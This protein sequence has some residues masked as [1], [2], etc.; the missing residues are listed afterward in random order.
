MSHRSYIYTLPIHALGKHFDYFFGRLNPAPSF[1][2]RAASEHQ[3]IIRL[4]EDASGLAAKFSPT[5]YLQGS[6]K[7]Q[8]AIYTINDVDI[9]ARCSLPALSVALWSEQRWKRDELFETIAAPLLA[10]PR[11]RDRVRYESASMCIKVDLGIKVEI[12]PVV[13]R[14]WLAG[15]DDEPF[16]FYRPKTGCWENGYARHH[17]QRLSDKNAQPRTGGNFIPAIK[18]LKHLR[19]HYGLDAVSFHLEC[20]LYSLPDYLFRGNT[21]TSIAAIL[22]AIAGTSAEGWYHRRGMR[23][24]IMTPCGERRLFSQTEWTWER[25]KTFHQWVVFFDLLAQAACRAPDKAM[26]IQVWQL[27][28]GE[29]FFPREVS[30]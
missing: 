9:V 25:W 26:A 14:P 8:T 3:S 27:L 22:H 18:V 23:S 24:P 15:T 10:D 13:H 5:C 11:Y 19:T 20:L 29:D 1:E 28:L 30:A 16:L 4:I 21:A 7:Q 2:K 12:L 6:Y 17:Q